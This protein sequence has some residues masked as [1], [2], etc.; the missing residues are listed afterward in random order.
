MPRIRADAAGEQVVSFRLGRGVGI[1]S[2]PGRNEL[3]IAYDNDPVLYVVDF[4]TGG[5]VAE[6]ALPA[7]GNDAAVLDAEGGKLYV[8][9]WP[10][11]RWTASIWPSAGWSAG[12]RTPA[13]SRT[14]S[15][16][17]GTR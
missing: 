7:F 6:V 9:S 14:C 16:W 11:A 13:S 15:A 2:S 4:K 17:P 3:Y 10:T 1:T 8:A 5:T 12:T